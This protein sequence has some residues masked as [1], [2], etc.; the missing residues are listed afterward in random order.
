MAAYFLVPKFPEI[1]GSST[2]VSVF[3]EVTFREDYCKVSVFSCLWCVSWLE[4]YRTLLVRERVRNI[5][6]NA[7]PSTELHRLAA[8]LQDLRNCL[9]REE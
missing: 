6:R 9:F 4:Q 2:Y 7:R 1:F 8:F 3:R 5:K